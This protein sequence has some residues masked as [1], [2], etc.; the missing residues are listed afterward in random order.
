[1]QRV[2][3]EFYFDFEKCDGE[4]PAGT[5]KREVRFR[6]FTLGEIKERGNK[7]NIKWLTDDTLDDP[8]DLP[9]PADLIAEAVSEPEAAADELN[10]ITIMITLPGAQ[11]TSQTNKHIKVKNNE[12]NRFKKLFW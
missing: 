2:F 9:E 1:M 5:N 4:K 10:E 7:L 8:D 12:S 3:I 11:N 6:A